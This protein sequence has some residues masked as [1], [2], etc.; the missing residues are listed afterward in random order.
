LIGTFLVGYA[1]AFFRLGP[2][3]INVLATAVSCV[4]FVYFALA[5][6]RYRLLGW[7]E[8]TSSV[9]VRFGQPELIFLIIMVIPSLAVTRDGAGQYIFLPLTAM[10]FLTVV[11][12]PLILGVILILPAAAAG[13]DKPIEFGWNI[14]RGSWLR[15]FGLTLICSVPSTVADRIIS[16][17]MQSYPA[18]AGVSQEIIAYLMG[19][20]TI[21]AICLAYRLRFENLSDSASQEFT[22]LRESSLPPLSSPEGSPAW[23]GP[24]RAAFELFMLAIVSWITSLLIDYDLN[25]DPTYG[26]NIEPWRLKWI[27]FTFAIGAIPVILLSFLILLIAALSC[28]V[29]R[30]SKSG[31]AWNWYRLSFT[32][33]VV[34]TIAFN[35]FIWFGGRHLE[36]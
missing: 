31:D 13:H 28:L 27:V 5:M 35:Y 1:G 32:I 9:K 19:A 36:R 30:S 24:S 15:L 18:V 23:R 6:H 7:N 11:S 3:L 14:G 29:R 8:A 21:T 33:T 2:N 17:F 10:L 25:R 22:A 12:A 26:L 4:F 34:F 20:V 16:P